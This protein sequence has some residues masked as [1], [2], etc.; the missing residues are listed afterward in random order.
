VK[1][2]RDDGDAAADGASAKEMACSSN[3]AFDA[4][5]A[6]ESTSLASP[7]LTAPGEFADVPA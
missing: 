2:G 4:R 6:H 1:R 5:G 3:G 7:C